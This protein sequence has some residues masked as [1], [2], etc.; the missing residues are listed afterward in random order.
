MSSWVEMGKHVLEL[1]EDQQ[2]QVSC[3]A[4][5]HLQPIS[6]KRM[7]CWC[8][9]SPLL[10]CADSE[11]FIFSCNGYRHVGDFKPLPAAAGKDTERSALP[12]SPSLPHQR[13]KSLSVS[14]GGCCTTAGLS[15]SQAFWWLPQ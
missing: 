9:P 6:L 1:V 14:D 12:W 3:A 11:L 7:S 8:S 15:V 2:Q 13:A 5:H 10:Y 4:V